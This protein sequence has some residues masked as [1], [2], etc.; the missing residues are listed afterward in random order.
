V[1]PKLRATEPTKVQFKRRETQIAAAYARDEIDPNA[2]A[3]DQLQQT[4]QQNRQAS[5]NERI[6]SAVLNQVFHN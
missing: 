4:Q 5:L 1:K 3:S 2:H 6:K